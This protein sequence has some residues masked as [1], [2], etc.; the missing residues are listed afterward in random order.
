MFDVGFLELALIGVVA[1]LVLG[2]ERLPKVAR[3]AGMW[4]GRAR[5]MVSNVKRDIEQEMQAEELKRAFEENKVENPLKDI[6]EE[7]RE[8][9]EQVKKDADEIAEKANPDQS[10]RDKHPEP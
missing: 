8:T 5:R 1:L 7:T 2:P 10:P 9:F 4:A 6:V 3:T